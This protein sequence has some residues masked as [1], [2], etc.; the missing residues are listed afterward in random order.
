VRADLVERN[1]AAGA[2]GRPRYEY[3]TVGAGTLTTVT[4]R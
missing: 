1:A 3:R 4:N 2:V